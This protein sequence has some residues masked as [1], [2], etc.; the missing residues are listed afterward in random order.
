MGWDEDNFPGMA[1]GISKTELPVYVSAD[2]ADGEAATIGIVTEGTTNNYGGGIAFGS[3]QQNNLDGGIY[4]ARPGKMLL[5]VG[6]TGTRD[7]YI[8]LELDDDNLQIRTPSRYDHL[9]EGDLEVDGVTTFDGEFYAN[10]DV[11]ITSLPAANAGNLLSYESSGKV[12]DSGISLSQSSVSGVSGTGIIDSA[13]LA[14]GFL[15][16]RWVVAVS[17]GT[18]YRMSHMM[19]ITN[20]SAG[21]GNTEYNEQSTNDVGDT[22]GIALSIDVSGADLALIATI[23]SGTWDIRYSRLIL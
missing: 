4:F 17:D 11:F 21:S 6:S 22:S 19:S 5:C 3:N 23:S 10:D 18:N 7:T 2:V 8:A 20:G 14:Q 12:V 16:I 1:L 15:G 13:P 9:M